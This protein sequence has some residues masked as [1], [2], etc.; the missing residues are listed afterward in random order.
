MNAM[1]MTTELA[2]SIM[3]VLCLLYLCSRGIGKH[4][5]GYDS[6]GFP[7]ISEELMSRAQIYARTTF[8][9]LCDKFEMEMGEKWKVLVEDEEN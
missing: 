7:I 3:D 1:E 8:V 5:I 2:N 4:T 6:D 9:T